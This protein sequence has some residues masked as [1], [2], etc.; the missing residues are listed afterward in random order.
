GSGQRLLDV[1]CGPGALTAELVRRGGPSAV[2]AADPSEPFVA[3]AEARHPEVDVRQASAGQLPFDAGS[4]DG[5]LAP[6]VVHFMADPTQGLREMARVARAGG[7]VAA[8]VWDHAGGG[9]PLSSF[10]EAARSLD[11]DVDDESAR[12]GVG[13][14]QL[15]QILEAA[16]VRDVE[17]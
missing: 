4:V 13:Q 2:A 11:P 12:A 5:V 15:V 1:G 14:G 16:G 6:L 17:E 9:G 10:W 8:C 3:A 7:V